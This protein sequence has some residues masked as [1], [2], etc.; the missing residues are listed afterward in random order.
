VLEPR[1]RL[2]VEVAA[3]GPV[4]QLTDL[5]DLVGRK[6]RGGLVPRLGDL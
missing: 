6:D 5:L 2:A 3:P 4:A 1:K